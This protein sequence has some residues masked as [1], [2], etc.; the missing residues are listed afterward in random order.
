MLK[1]DEDFFGDI[2]VMILSP[3]PFSLPYLAR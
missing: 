1:C 2:L 3:G